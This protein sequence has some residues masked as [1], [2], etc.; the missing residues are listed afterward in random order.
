[1][2]GTDDLLARVAACRIVVTGS[3]HAAVI[4]LS[5]GVSIVAIAGSDYYIRKFRGL[6][7][8]FDGLC[9]VEIAGAPELTSRVESAIRDA[10]RCA[11]ARRAAL[12]DAA[13]RQRAAAAAAYERLFTLV[14]TRRQLRPARR[15]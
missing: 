15:A 14:E 6:A 12:L 10:W 1:V 7:S 4:A 13:S 2:N 8:Q 3:Y 11:P 9:R 5:M